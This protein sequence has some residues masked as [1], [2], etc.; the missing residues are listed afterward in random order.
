MPEELLEKL[1]R[2]FELGKQTAVLA[3]PTVSDVEYLADINIG[4]PPQKLPFIFDTGSSDLWV[5]STDTKADE[6][7]GQTLWAPKNSSTATK[8]AGSSWGVTY[9]DKSESSGDVYLDVVNVGGLIVP[10]QAVEVANEV[11]SQF[12]GDSLA[13]GILGLAYDKGNSV[14]PKPQSTWFSNIKDSLGSPLFTIR[15]R[16]Q[17][18][19]WCI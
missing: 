2:R 7:N 16:H 11:S 12:T 5:F 1:N 17:A 3:N 9:G 19:T 10:N 8:L 13:S 14:I 18:S 15:L 6:V 4:T